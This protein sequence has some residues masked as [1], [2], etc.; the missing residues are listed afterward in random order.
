LDRRLN[1]PQNRSGRRREEKT[2]SLLGIE[3]RPPELSRLPGDTY[4]VLR[5]KR[6]LRDLENRVLRTIIWRKRD[7]TTGGWRKL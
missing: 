2:L 4:S 7:Q 3:P 1:E 5:E 6:R